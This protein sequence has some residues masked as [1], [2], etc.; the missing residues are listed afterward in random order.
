[1]ITART[2][3]YSLV[4]VPALLS[5]QA[6]DE[7]VLYYPKPLAKTRWQTP[8]QPITRL[9]DVKAKHKGEASWRELVIHDENSR[10]FLV[11]EPPGT[12][13]QQRLYPD[14]AAWWAIL[15]G[16]VRFEVERPDRRFEVVEATKG[17]YVFVPER[18]L[19]AY[20][21]IGNQAAITFEVTLASATPLYP[22]RPAHA[23]SGPVEHRP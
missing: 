6:S 13:H 17:S 7:R 22:D 23:H 14:S 19:H 8:M 12:K 2:L 20:D 15:D 21:V 16:R 3:A 4:V 18:M 9:A 1:M 5:A 10:A 11:H